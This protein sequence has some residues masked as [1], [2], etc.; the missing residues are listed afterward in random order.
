MRQKPFVKKRIIVAGA[1]IIVLA[2]IGILA[3]QS[4]QD[5]QSKGS[6]I[7]QKERLEFAAEAGWVNPPSQSSFVP[8]DLS[9]PVRLAIGGLGLADNNQNQQLGDLVTVKLTGAPGFNL[10]ERQSLAAVLRELNLSWSGFIRANDAVRVGKLLKVDWFLLGTEATINGKDSLVVRVVD[11]RTG[12]IHDGSVFPRDKSLEKLAGDLTTF[13]RQSRQSAANASPKVYLAVGAFEDLSPNNRQA[14]FPAQLRG[15]LTTAYRGSQVTF[16]EREYVETLLREVYLD[17]AGLTEDSSVNPPR[18]MQSAFWLIS[19]GYQSYETTNLQV[20]LNL[21]V[22]RIFGSS[23]HFA[24]YGQPDESLCRRVKASVDEA[25]NQNPQAIIPTRITEVRA[26]M[27]IGKRLAMAESYSDPASFMSFGENY[28]E[29]DAQEAAR[30]RRNAEEAIRSFQTVLLLEPENREA[31]LFLAACLRKRII[32]RNGEA[33]D[34]YREFLENPG[35]DQWRRI[36]QWGLSSSLSTWPENP[37]EK[38]RWFSMALG[39]STNAATIEFYKQNL[40]AAETE[41]AIRQGDGPDA[42]KL[43]EK[44][45]FENI[46]STYRTRQGHGGTQYSAFGMWDFVHVYGKERPADGISRLL[47]LYPKMKADFPEIAPNLLEAV[48]CIQTNANCPLVAELEQ[49]LDW[50]IAHPDEFFQ[51]KNKESSSLY[52]WSM[53]QKLYPLALKA[54]ERDRAVRGGG[55]AGKLN[56]EDSIA[57][58]YAYMGAK[59]WKDALEVFDCLSNRPVMMQT[60]GPWG[61]GYLVP[62]LPNQLS[63]VCRKELGLS[64]VRGPQEF[65]MGK[66]FFSLGA[67]STFTVDDEGLWL[68]VDGK[69]MRLNFDL[70][71][72]L[73]IRLPMDA[74]TEISAICISAS[75]VW[76]GTIGDGL[77]EYDKESSKCRRYA[78]E[79]GLMMNGIANLSLAGDSLAIGYGQEKRS[80]PRVS[81]GSLASNGGLGRLNLTTR[82]FI[83]FT[84]SIVEG[85]DARNRTSG[86]M[87]ME[88]TDRPTSRGIRSLQ[89]DTKGN[90]W[91]VTTFHPLR[92]YSISQDDWKGFPEVRECSCL[93]ADDAH[94]FAGTVA[95]PRISML[96]L[97]GGSWRALKAA[98]DYLPGEPTTMT[99]D[100]NSLWVGGPGYM[101]NLDPSQDKLL[102]IA[103]VKT[104]TV[105][106]IQVGGGYVW[107]QF[108]GNLFRAP[109]SAIQ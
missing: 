39:K 80:N 97:K 64:D 88:S 46:V 7:T 56:D 55:K 1:S 33:R 108:E 61:R 23:K 84:P 3:L 54:L 8:I 51:G 27:N 76:V 69:L 9:K 109:S 100:G 4:W 65:D 53:K 96:S 95:G 103:Y 82:K 49:T 90:I 60:S 37:D 44:Q 89:A 98:N 63:A 2:G 99:L 104:R 66:P 10:V 28:Q 102:H 79:D 6:T 14:G 78:L 19:G 38:Q 43:A 45:L 30:R 21:E 5:K 18:P 22:Q 24:L 62:V 87:V 106:R 20:E 15:Y 101:A 59:R 34:I 94:V 11:A 13:M 29:L 32:G 85:A 92:R 52:E 47:E 50:E 41:I 67:F 36:A 42:A 26:H 70:K 77:I 16:L 81:S 40:A 86:N 72:N 25:I 105:D 58:G 73:V 93:A 31:K 91:F 12:I 57:V 17:M 48:V 74:G 71:T 75:S 107:A 68:G 35:Q 83:S